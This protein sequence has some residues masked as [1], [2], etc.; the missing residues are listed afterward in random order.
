MPSRKRKASYLN[1][2]SDEV[3]EMSCIFVI[4]LI[5]KC[6]IKSY[7]KGPINNSH[8]LL[9]FNIFYYILFL[10]FK[11]E[12][13]PSIERIIETSELGNLKNS[14]TFQYLIRFIF[15]HWQTQGALE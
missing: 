11:I 15:E 5:N 1:T 10:G 4:L 8:I 6:N 13:L 2:I 7:Q 9:C 14:A 12:D 3:I